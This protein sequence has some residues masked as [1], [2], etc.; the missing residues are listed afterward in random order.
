MYV[1]TWLSTELDKIL[2]VM[3]D[4]KQNTGKAIKYY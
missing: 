2:S 4:D 1:L 3:N